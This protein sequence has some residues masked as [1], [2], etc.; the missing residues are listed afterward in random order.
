ML[1]E[2][3]RHIHNDKATSKIT[4]NSTQGHTVLLTGSTGTL[5][6]YLLDTLLQDPSVTHIY[7]L[8]RSHDSKNVQLQRNIQF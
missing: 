2:F 3:L 5:G 1:Q 6:T 7:C 8:T 4:G